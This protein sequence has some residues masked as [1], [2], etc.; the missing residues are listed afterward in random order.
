[1]KRLFHLQSS[2]RLFKH[3]SAAGQLRLLISTPADSKQPNAHAD[4]H[5]LLRYRLAN[6]VAIS[7]NTFSLRKPK[8]QNQQYQTC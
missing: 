2:R 8:S 7:H 1:M 3:P 5:A 6:V 4:G